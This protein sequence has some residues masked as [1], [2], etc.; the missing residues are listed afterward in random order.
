MAHHPE[1]RR[2]PQ[3]V[4]EAHRPGGSLVL[5]GQGADHKN[6]GNRRRTAHLHSLPP[7]LGRNVSPTMSRMRPELDRY[8]F[9][10]TTSATSA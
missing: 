8:R 10:K 2:R 6:A 3:Q 4:A 7:Q 5:Q 1:I 9:A